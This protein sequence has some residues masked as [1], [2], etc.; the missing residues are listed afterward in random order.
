MW[1]KYVFEGISDAVS[2]PEEEDSD[3][4]DMMANLDADAALDTEMEHLEI[5][6]ND[7]PLAPTAEAIIEGPGEVT[8]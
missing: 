4:E 6:E 8:S 5:E 1:E 7:L 3:Y 2:E